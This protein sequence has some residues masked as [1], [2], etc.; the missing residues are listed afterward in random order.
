MDIDVRFSD[1]E[2]ICEEGV[3]LVEDEEVEDNGE[4]VDMLAELDVCKKGVVVLEEP[5][6]DKVISD[7]V[8]GVGLTTGEELDGMLV[9]VREE[10]REEGCVVETFVVSTERICTKDN[11]I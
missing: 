5:A 1:V 9:L 11:N 4:D 3:L 8:E 7:I 6:E 2:G 10:D